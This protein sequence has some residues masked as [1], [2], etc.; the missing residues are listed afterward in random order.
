MF[1]DVCYDA[2]WRQEREGE[3]PDNTRDVI[4]EITFLY[5]I[6]NAKFTKFI[7]FSMKFP[8]FQ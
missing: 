2:T 5:L 3:S 7:H 1:D 6:R 8:D 4:Y